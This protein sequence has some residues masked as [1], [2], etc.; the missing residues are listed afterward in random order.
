MKLAFNEATTLE[1][2]NL[3]DDLI[4]CEKH[5][6]DFIEIRLDKLK[7]YLITH[8]VG[9]LQNFFSS[10]NLKPLSLNALEEFTFRNQTEFNLM[11]QDL[12]LMS[13]V[14]TAIDCDTIVAVPTFGIEKDWEEI[15]RE[16]VVR[17]REFLDLIKGTDLKLALE[18][19][20]YPDCS[21]NTLDKA[22]EV[23]EV[24]GNP[25]VGLVLDCFHFYAM[26]SSYEALKNLSIDDLFLFHI[27]DCEGKLPGVLRDHHRLWPGEGVIPLETIITL[28]YEKGFE[29]PASV[30]LFRPEYW[31]LEAEKCIS[32]AKDKTIHLLEKALQKILK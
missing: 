26:N 5:G 16:T 1:N 9:D 30:E 32:K 17:L 24:V 18:F 21:I 14:A 27:D 13:E 19:V 23:V 7:E 20:G 15:K 4:L 6:F 3:E 12:S 25:Q 29:G 8:S 28:L 22:Q 11:K 2:S 10:A 31:E